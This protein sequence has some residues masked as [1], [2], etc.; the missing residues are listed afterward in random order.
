L[1]GE[2][3]IEAECHEITAI[4]TLL[5]MLSLKIALVTI[6]VSGCQTRIAKKF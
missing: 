6:E 5:E 4:P 3:D 1:L 2:L